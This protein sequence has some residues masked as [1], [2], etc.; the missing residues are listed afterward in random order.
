MDPEAIRGE[1]TAGD[2]P[3]RPPGDRVPMSKNW[4]KVF[5]DPVHNLISFADTPCDRLL[6]ELIDTRE[7]QRLRRIK[8]MGV[9]ELVFPGANHSRFAHSLGV[10][11]TARL[12]LDQLTA[13]RTAGPS[14][15]SRA[16]S[17]SPRR[18][19]TTSATGRSRTPSS[20]SPGRHHEAYTRAVIQDDSTEV[21]QCLRRFDPACPS[22][23]A[24]FFDEDADEGQPGRRPARLPRPHRL[25]PAR[26]R[27]LRL[28]APRQPRHGH[29]LR[30]LRPRLDDRAV[31]PRRRRPALLPHP[32]GPR[33][34]RNVPLRA[35]PHVPHGLLPQDQPGRRSHAQTPLPPA[36]GTH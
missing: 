29:E 18:C 9:T 28:P 30:R 21:H 16:P 31:P 24:L 27:P 23:C 22:G 17:S 20:R 13:P 34:R 12:F 7:V 1:N 15:R 36:R 11:H 14:P 33:R 8:Q 10:L 6:L 2:A 26:R 19:C 4:P 35:L 3:D 25:G 32:Q 5:R